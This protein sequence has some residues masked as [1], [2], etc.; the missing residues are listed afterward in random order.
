MGFKEKYIRNFLDEL[1]ESK[2]FID[3]RDYNLD[4]IENMGFEKFR[5]E[6]VKGNFKLYKYYPNVVR[7]EEN[8][9]TRNY[10]IEA[11]EHNTVYL[12]DA[13]N[14]DDSFDC[15]VDIDAVK[16]DNLRLNKYC[17]YFG[18]DVSAIKNDNSILASKISDFLYSKLVDNKEQEI[19]DNIHDEI[20]RLRAENFV[21]N[22]MLE[23][24]NC[25]NYPIALRNTL[26]KERHDFIESL[27]NFKIAC[28]SKSPFLNRM[29]SSA[30]GDN[31]RGFCLE[32]S[33]DLSNVELI[34]DVYL[35]LFPVIYSQKRN[36]SSILCENC[37]ENV[38]L[39]TLW[40]LYFNGLLRKSLYWIDQQEWRLI[41]LDKL[42]SQNPI[43]FFKI[44]K[45][46]LGDK[47]PI[48]E[49]K[50]I[51]EICNKKKID[52]ICVVREPNSFNLIECKHKC[53]LCVNED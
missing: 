34:E 24:I 49:K 37:D 39:E 51:I 28:F 53:N 13:I 18:I 3:G 42:M 50:H 7:K 4:Y 36:D 17:E 27:S 45:V 35:N 44:T 26:D 8:G 46:Y 11:L 23:I 25:G 38:N 2:C 47:M 31:N 19:Y 41:M 21:K 15:A 6:F 20:K 14:F 12:N 30:Y 22:V 29:W 32:Y 43:N 16:F 33:I 52:Y 40:Q 5:S 9:E 1:C 10:S 48:E